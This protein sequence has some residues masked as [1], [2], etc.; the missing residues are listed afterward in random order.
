MIIRSQG[1]GSV[2]ARAIGRDLKGK[3]NPVRYLIG[4]AL[5]LAGGVQANALDFSGFAVF[6][7]VSVLWLIPDR[8]IERNITAGT[9]QPGPWRAG[10]GIVRGRRNE[11][12]HAS[13]LGALN[14]G[15]AD[16]AQ[17]CGEV[18]ASARGHA[19]TVP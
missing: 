14:S 9:A 8:R 15:T 18:L 5:A 13:L 2:L 19:A 4:I 16:F 3:T 11:H 1:S 12:P 10:A 17:P 6:A 7:G